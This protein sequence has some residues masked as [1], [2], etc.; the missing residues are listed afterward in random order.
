MV[1][2]KIKHRT[3]EIKDSLSH[4]LTKKTMMVW[5][6][7][8]VGEMG[9]QA[10]C[11]GY[12]RLAKAKSYIRYT[13]LGEGL[14]LGNGVY[15][16]RHQLDALKATLKGVDQALVDYRMQQMFL[17]YVGSWPGKLCRGV[18]T[19]SR[20]MLSCGSQNGG[21]VWVGL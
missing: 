9:F 12:A 6:L 13:E 11:V 4:R 1:L 16:P 20:C 8:M 17:K 18:T 3:P 14:H 19:A 15:L 2:R 21:R 7:L 10:T 5:L